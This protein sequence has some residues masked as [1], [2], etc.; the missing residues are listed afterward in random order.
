MTERYPDGEPYPEHLLRGIP[1]DFAGQGVYSDR[2]AFEKAVHR[3]HEADADPGGRAEPWRPGEVVLRWPR[4][5]LGYELLPAGEGEGEDR[6]ADRSEEGEVRRA[7][8][9]LIHL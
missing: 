8:V 5:L 9:L 1:W 7:R 6:L 3:H 2:E 4:V